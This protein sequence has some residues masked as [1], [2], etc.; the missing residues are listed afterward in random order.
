MLV[1]V[2][3][4]LLFDVCHEYVCIGWGHLCAHGCALCLLVVLV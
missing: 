1:V 3:F 4:D 2:V